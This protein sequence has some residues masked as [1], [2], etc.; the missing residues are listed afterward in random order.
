M[1]HFLALTNF[2]EGSKTL[3]CILNH[4]EE[5]LLYNYNYL[6]NIFL[7][8][9][10]LTYSYKSALRIYVYCISTNII[11]KIMQSQEY[12]QYKHINKKKI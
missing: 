11:D 1:L 5:K 3:S 8:N 4:L 6:K 12:F 7:H 2:I 9:K 10:Y